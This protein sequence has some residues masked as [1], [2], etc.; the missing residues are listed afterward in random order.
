MVNILNDL[1]G[2]INGNLLLMVN[3]ILLNCYI[4]VLHGNLKFEL[5]DRNK[6]LNENKV[7][8]FLK[9]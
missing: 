1:N 9:N 5:I 3:F 7:I 8:L 6:F 2:Y 4:L